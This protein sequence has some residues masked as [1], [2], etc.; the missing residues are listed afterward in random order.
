[1]L[2]AYKCLHIFEGDSLLFRWFIA[3][4]KKE[5]VESVPVWF[6]VPTVNSFSYLLLFN[7]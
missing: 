6:V 7:P 2:K 5:Y 4:V 1:M 3:Y